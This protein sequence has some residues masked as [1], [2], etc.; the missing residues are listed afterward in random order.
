MRSSKDFIT[1]QL[2]AQS[3]YLAPDRSEIRLL[4]VMRGGGLCHCTLPPGSI[5]GAVKHKTVEEIWYVI[6]GAGHIWRKQAD[7]EE[8]VEVSPGACLTIPVDTHFQFRNI[9]S[10]PLCIIIAT[11]PPWPGEGEAVNAKGK[12]ESTAP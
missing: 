1:A 6:Q 8:V 5:S 3:D 2:S 10:E 9:G 12:W 7:R 11:I 4:P